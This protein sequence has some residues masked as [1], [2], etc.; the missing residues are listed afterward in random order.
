MK[1]LFTVLLLSLFVGAQQGSDVEAAI[2]GLGVEFSC[3]AASSGPPWPI[4]INVQ[5]L[6]TIDFAV[7]TGPN[8]DYF[9]LYAVPQPSNY[10][11]IALTPYG[12][13]DLDIT[14]PAFG[15]VYS[16]YAFSFNGVFYSTNFIIPSSVVP[17]GTSVAVQ[18]LVAD[19]THPSGARLSNALC[20]IN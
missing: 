12:I 13:V 17:T 6:P 4:C 7:L 20:V 14:N 2:D 18:A 5:S 10:Y 11:G 1:Y 16:G 3:N 15:L 9:E 8:S 19:A